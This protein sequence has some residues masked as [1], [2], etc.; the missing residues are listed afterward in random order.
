MA[1]G[2]IGRTAGRRP[3]FSQAQFLDRFCRRPPGFKPGGGSCHRKENSVIGI[4]FSEQ[5]EREGEPPTGFAGGGGDAS[6]YN[7][8]GG[9]RLRHGINPVG[10]S[11]RQEY[12]YLLEGPAE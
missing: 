9:R 10:R 12:S 8:R 5:R 1:A 6:P 3:V 11:R 4:H 7:G 2:I